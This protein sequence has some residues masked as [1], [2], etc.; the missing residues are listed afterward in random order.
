M[1][2][3]L[4]RDRRGAIAI[5]SAFVLVAV[6][7]FSALAVEFGRGL[8][9][10]VQNQQTADI[11]AYSGALV[12]DATSSTSAVDS[13]VAN[14]VRLNCLS[15]TVPPPVINTIK[16]T[17]SVTVTTSDPLLLTRVLNANMANLPVSAT[18]TA[19]WAGG[20]AACII[21]LDSA[22]SGVYLSGGTSLTASQ[23]AIASNATVSEGNCG[24]T[25]TTPLVAYNSGTPPFTPS[26]CQP[27]I[28]PPAGTSS[29][30]YIKQTITD[31]ICGSVGNAPNQC[32]N[33]AVSAATIRL[34]TVT[35]IAS[36]SG[37]SASS[38]SDIDFAYSTPLSG[39]PSG[40]TASFS[41][42]TWT[43]TCSGNGPFSFGNIS[44]GGGITVNFNT[45]GSASATYNFNEIDDSG[46]ALNFGPGT[47]NIAGGILTGGGSTTSFGAGTFNIGT[48]PSSTSC[49]SATGYSI[50]NTG[51]MLT[52]GGPS[53]FVLAGGIYNKGGETLTL[54]SGTSNS[55]DIGTAGDGNSIYV[56]GGAYTSF[57]DATGTGDLFEAAGSIGSGGGSCL[58]ISAADEHD[59]NGSISL[60]GGTTLGAGTYTVTD[61][62][63]FGNS[64]GG[65]VSCGEP[66]YGNGTCSFGVAGPPLTSPTSSP[67][68]AP[69]PGEG[70][71]LVIGGATTISSC[72]GQSGTVS[73]CIAA[74]FSNVTLTA[75]PPSGPGS[76]PTCQADTLQCIAVIGPTTASGN[77]T[78]GAVLT[79][80]ASN[81]SVTG[82]FYFPNAPVSLSGGAS[83]GSAGCLDVIG[84]QVSVIAGTALASA[85]TNLTP[86]VGKT[87]ILVN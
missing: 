67:A 46:T 69:M 51:T 77:P 56:G 39:L 33:S 61:Y 53:T 15:C 65:D 60:A 70:V 59:I 37:P 75:P 72:G 19:Q 57:A 2:H 48:L 5:L 49:N 78:A 71:T 14:I 35:A 10:H 85:C 52:F 32:S 43:V 45:G 62:V 25:I 80:G 4:L 47:Y 34:A 27:F 8:F 12:Y 13:A 6:I 7:G 58:W 76:P 38:G 3:G 1:F 24:D 26:G 21:A 18:A 40:C 86:Y 16:Q 79:A 23:C 83:L 17:V 87:I 28:V 68:C 66:A 54:G 64:S 29:V 50:C 82:A 73:F 9:R 44:L 42:K 31:P 63:A 55:F 22:G 84:S 81:T 41:S 20:T 74:G 30:Q 11:A 36:P